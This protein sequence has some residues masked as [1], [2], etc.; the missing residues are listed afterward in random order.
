MKHYPSYFPSLILTVFFILA[1]FV[2]VIFMYA[3]AVP[4]AEAASPYTC[5]REFFCC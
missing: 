4:A 2:A 3:A 5:V 1:A